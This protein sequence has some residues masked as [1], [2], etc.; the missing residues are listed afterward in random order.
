MIAGNTSIHYAAWDGD[1][2]MINGE[3]IWSEK[4]THSGKNETHSENEAYSG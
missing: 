2:D 4:E 3:I 1:L